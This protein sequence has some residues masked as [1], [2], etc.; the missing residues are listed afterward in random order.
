MSTRIPVALLGFLG[1]AFLAGCSS[2]RKGGDGDEAREERVA[3]T[4]LPAPARATAE[5]LTAGGKIE[6]IDKETEKGRT[7]YDVEAEV[8]GKHVE[9]TIGADG[10]VL[11]DETAI[12]WK[13]LPAAVQAA[14]EKFF[15]T[16][17]GL[18]PS[19]VNE[20]GKTVYE[21]EGKKNGKK[22]AA[23]FDASGKILEEED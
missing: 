2:D 4:D 7:V 18:A 19:A 15:G 22:V 23:T 14:A 10:A 12:E 9:Y 20:E 3:M 1:V 6:K 8:G 21:I 13:E 5:R 17:A 11:G 16:S